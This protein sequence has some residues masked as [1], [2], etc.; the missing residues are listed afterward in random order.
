MDPHRM[1]TKVLFLDVDGV[2]N[3]R[4]L[5][6]PGNPQPICPLAWKRVVSVVSATRAKIVLSSTWRRNDHPDD[7]YHAKLRRIGLFEHTHEDWRTRYDLPPSCDGAIREWPSRGDEIAE[8]L[9]RHPEVTTYAIVD[10]DA[11]M[12]WDQRAVFVQTTFESGLTDAHRDILIEL[13]DASA[14]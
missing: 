1:T 9:G 6:V 11:D 7:P 5:F 8:W 14:A 12:R 13:L 10:D 4:A 2:L 3:H